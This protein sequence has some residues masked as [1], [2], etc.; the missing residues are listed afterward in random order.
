MSY[1]NNKSKLMKYG[2]FKI[3]AL[4]IGI[5]I[6]LVASEIFLRVYKFRKYSTNT[7]RM[8]EGSDLIYEHRPGI[9]FVNEEGI[10]IRY[11]SMGFI[12]DEIGPKE[13]NAFRILGM[14]DSI[15]AGEY[16]PESERYLNRLGPILSARSGRPVEVI[17]AGVTGYNSWQE[18]ELLKIKGLSVEPDLV[19][20]GLCLNDDIG[21]RPELKK[22]ISGR[23]VE[24]RRHHKKA[25]YFDFIYQ[26]SYVCQALYDGLYFAKRALTREERGKY[27]DYEWTPDICKWQGPLK[28]MIALTKEKNA[29]ILF[30][31]FPLERQVLRKE[32]ASYAPL[33]DFFRNENVYFL[34]LIDLYNSASDN[35]LYIDKDPI[36]PNAYASGIAAEAVADFIMQKGILNDK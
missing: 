25:R 8:V 12:G 29:E 2:R 10:N 23:I 19:V 11:N 27:D 21:W 32:G 1:K 15:A 30:V 13:K 34:D 6:A 7:V 22:T 28:Q 24:V 4:I 35:T 17:N 33:A 26:R 16:L 5:V 18:L 9:S 14:G 3:F 20:V 31:A 36:H